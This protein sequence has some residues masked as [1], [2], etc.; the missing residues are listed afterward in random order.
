MYGI[1]FSH[2]FNIYVLFYKVIEYI[3]RIE[4][5]GVSVCCG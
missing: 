2:L 5:W 1:T 3:N 4:D